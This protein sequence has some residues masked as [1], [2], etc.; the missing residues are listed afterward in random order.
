[1]WTWGG[2]R[3]RGGV[4]VGPSNFSLLHQEGGLCTDTRGGYCPGCQP[5][6]TRV[7]RAATPARSPFNVHTHSGKHRLRYVLPLSL[8]CL[9]K[10]LLFRP[11]P[12]TPVSPGTGAGRPST[13]ALPPKASGTWSSP[14]LPSS[15]SASSQGGTLGRGHCQVSAPIRLSSTQTCHVLRFRASR[16]YPGLRKSEPS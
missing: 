9:C 2:L 10:N 7:L 16:P 11:P 5:P 4:G 6:A 8:C 15:L 12:P 3:K 13:A 1:M 14:R